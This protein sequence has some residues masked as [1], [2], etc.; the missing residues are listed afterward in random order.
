MRIFLT[1][2]N[3]YIGGTVAAKLL[4]KG[5]QV[6]GL[7]RDQAKAGRLEARG[8]TPVLGNLD[9]TDLLTSEVRKADVAI[10]IA[11]IDHRPSADAFLEGVRGTGKMFIQAGGSAIVADCAGGEATDA[12]YEDDTPVHPL[13]LR[14]V[15]NE[16]RKHVLAAAKDGAHTVMIAPPMIYGAGLGLNPDS[17]QIPRMIAV[18]RKHGIAK[19]VGKSAN[20]WSNVHVEDLADLYLTAMERAPAGAYYYAE[21]GENSMLEI[22]QAISRMLGYGGKTASMSLEEAAAEYGDVPANYSFG[23]N[24]RVRAIRARKELGWTPSRRALLDEIE[25]GSYA[26]QS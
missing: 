2:A 17:I 23:S 10:N 11:N 21:N 19:Y 3:G 12:V 24:S 8:I 13:P 9:D 26:A 16:L 15:R 22:C 7:V 5:H 1:G 18:A 20:R 6:S 25:Q 14:V 4:A